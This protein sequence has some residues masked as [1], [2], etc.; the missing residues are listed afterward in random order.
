MTSR[1]Q[2]SSAW[3]R[4]LL[5]VALLATAHSI[6]T[7]LCLVFSFSMS[8]ARFDSG[9][10]PTITE[11]MLAAVH[12]VLHWP[13]VALLYRVSPPSSFQ[14]PLGYIPIGLN[15]LL[16]ALLALAIVQRLGWLSA[17]EPE[18]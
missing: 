10:P 1:Q 3:H 14:G 15:S 18:V 16:W 17:R 9:T 11:R 5:F 4:E 13:V 6:A 2:R 8:M 7:G 12:G